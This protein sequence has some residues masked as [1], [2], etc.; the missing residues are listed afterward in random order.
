MQLLRLTSRSFQNRRTDVH[1][2]FATS[3]VSHRPAPAELP[4]AA[5]LLALERKRSGRATTCRTVHVTRR[6]G[7]YLVHLSWS[8]APTSTRLPALYSCRILLWIDLGIT[9]AVQLYS[10]STHFYREMAEFCEILICC[11]PRAPGWLAGW[12]TEN[13]IHMHSSSPECMQAARAACKNSE[14]WLLA[15]QP[16]CGPRIRRMADCAIFYILKIQLHVA[17]IHEY[18]ASKFCHY[19]LTM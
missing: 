2:E 15:T 4:T 6:Y 18:W 13:P 16:F 11:R 9:T 3:G 5:G 10:P 8:L 17:T 19:M 7:T 12:L 14:K 1:W